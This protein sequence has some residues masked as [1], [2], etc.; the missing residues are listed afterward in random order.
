MAPPAHRV[1]V[2]LAPDPETRARLAGAA[3]APDEERV[4]LHHVLR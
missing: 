1:F 4:F 3:A 2:A